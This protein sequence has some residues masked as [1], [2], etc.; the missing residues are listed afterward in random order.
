[1]CRNATFVGNECLERYLDR[2]LFWVKDDIASKRARMKELFYV[3]FVEWLL[4]LFLLF[5][6][7]GSV[8]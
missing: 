3:S 4:L 1:M 7:S 2:S 8:S 6:V 5:P